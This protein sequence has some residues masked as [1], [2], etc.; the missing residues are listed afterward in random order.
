MNA[1]RK[2]NEVLVPSR[3][4]IM[5]LESEMRKYDQL[6]L[7]VAHT[8]APGNYARSIFLP[9]GALVVGKIHKH[10]HLNIVSQG[11]VIV[12]TEFG[13]T[14]IE[15][16]YIFTSQP[17]TKRALYV[18][19]DC[20]W[21]TVHPSDETDVAKIEADIIAPS[22]DELPAPILNQCLELVELHT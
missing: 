10:A 22:Y 11:K 12:V 17:G 20:I 4:K 14:E 6:E 16:P 7:G 1:V 5:A 19:E 21:T 8:F 3:E 9:K 15:G 13:K 18:V 2:L